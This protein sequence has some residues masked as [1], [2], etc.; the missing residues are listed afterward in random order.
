[1]YK[2]ERKLILYNVG[3]LDFEKMWFILVLWAWK[4]QLLKVVIILSYHFWATRVVRWFCCMFCYCF[5]DVHYWEEAWNMCT[6]I[7]QWRSWRRWAKKMW[8]FLELVPWII[9]R[10]FYWFFILVSYYCFLII[11]HKS[12]LL[13]SI[14]LIED[15]Y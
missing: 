4:L 5:V 12:Y 7:V 14:G 8:N 15:W 10:I 2:I 1:M 13:K 9:S 11:V 6:P 3:K